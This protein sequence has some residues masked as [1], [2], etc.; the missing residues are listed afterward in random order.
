MRWPWTSK[1]RVE[2]LV[3]VLRNEMGLVKEELNRLESE[4]DIVYAVSVADQLAIEEVGS[5]GLNVRILPNVA[6]PQLLDD[7]MD[8]ADAVIDSLFVRQFE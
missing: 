2:G 4:F 7:A 8:A 5:P 3:G 6:D 1:A